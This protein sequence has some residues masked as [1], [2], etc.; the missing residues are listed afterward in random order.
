MSRPTPPRF[1][2]VCGDSLQK[3]AQAGVGLVG[4]CE[5]FAEC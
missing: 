3:P 1:D 4:A 5:H 2:V